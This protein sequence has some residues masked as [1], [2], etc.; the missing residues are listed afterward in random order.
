MTNVTESHY[1]LQA[2]ES[3]Q[4]SIQSTSSKEGPGERRALSILQVI[5]AAVDVRRR[6]QFFVWMQ[7]SFQTLLPHQLAV[8][9]VYERS[10]KQVCLEVF[11]SVV[12]PTAVLN[13]LTDGQS[14]LMQHIVSAWVDNRCRPLAVSVSKLSGRNMAPSIEALLNAGLL[15]LL[16]HGVSRPQRASEIE[17]LFVFASPTV[18]VTS[19]QLSCIE[20]LLPHLHSTYLR[21][22]SI[23]RE[24][25]DPRPKATASTTGYATASISDREEQVLGWVREG[26]SNQEIGVQLGISPLTVKNHVQKILRK[27]GA[28]NRAQAVARAMSMN[29][30]I[31]PSG[32]GGSAE[33]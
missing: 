19:A 31:R 18:G 5:E 11:N 8:C 3:C 29:L 23:E 22:Q 1:P 10:R 17:T 16:V 28:S 24:T 30:L 4:M 32:E 7:G 15:E 14:P 33:G 27:L 25:G 21:V 6:Y 2:M 13:L 20:L 9:G 12:V 26:M